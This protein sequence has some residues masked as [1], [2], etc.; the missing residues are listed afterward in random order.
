[1]LATPIQYTNT[2]QPPILQQPTELEQLAQL[3]VNGRGQSLQY[4]VNHLPDNLKALLG[5]VHYPLDDGRA[6]AQQ[7]RDGVALGAS[8]GSV[9]DNFNELYGGYAATL[10]QDVTSIMNSLNMLHAHMQHNYPLQ[11]QNFSDSWPRPS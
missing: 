9:I 7:I 4:I 8:D 10:Q 2:P 3:Y 6:L 5:T 1:M 11:Q